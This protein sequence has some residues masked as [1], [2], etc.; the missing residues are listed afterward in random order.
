M[1]NQT[2]KTSNEERIDDYRFIDYRLD[3]LEK[4]L[5]EG[6]RRLEKEYKESN[7]QILKTL[8]LMQESNNKQNQQLVELTQRLHTLEDKTQCIDKLKEVT[9]QHG[10]EIRTLYKRIDIYKQILMGVGV[11]VLL[12]LSVEIVRFI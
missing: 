7:K 4:N 11:G 5:A 8:E 2:K 3:Q 6:Q 12:A 1:C 9:T 10:E